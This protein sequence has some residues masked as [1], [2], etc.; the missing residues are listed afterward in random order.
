MDWIYLFLA[1]ILEILGTTCVKLS[2]GF[3][4]LWPTVGLIIFY[5]GSFRF[6]SEAIKTIELGTAYA[7]WSGVGT[8][9]VAV[10]GI[11]FFQEALSLVKISSILLIIIGVI[12]L[13]VY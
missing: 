13:K 10:I 11:I 12:G 2:Q 7:I 8:A 9:L 6:L 3:S 1:I 4:K 5:I